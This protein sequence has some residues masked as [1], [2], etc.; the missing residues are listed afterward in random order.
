VTNSLRLETDTQRVTYRLAVIAAHRGA[1]KNAREA[2][3]LALQVD[4]G[5]VDGLFL[6]GRIHAQG[7]EYGKAEA[8][9]QRAVARDPSRRDIEA[10]LDY[11][12][13][14]PRLAKWHFRG[15]VAILAGTVVFSIGLAAWLS[16]QAPA[17]TIR[18]QR[19]TIPN[20]TPGTGS[21]ARFVELP[22]LP[23][24]LQKDTSGHYVA[25]IPAG[26]LFS[27]NLTLSPEGEATIRDMVALIAGLPVGLVFELTGHSDSIPLRTDTQWDNAE[28]AA[29]RALIIARRLRVATGLPI[30]RFV[31]KSVGSEHPLASNGSEV[32]RLKNRTVVVR[33]VD[34]DGVGAV[35]PQSP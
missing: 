35:R 11:L 27:K 20:K 34:P 13:K 8:L 7:G 14:S 29:R 9:W 26:G 18:A 31:V 10:S 17:A 3:D 4:P 15:K 33:V 16:L 12:K 22:P 2:L 5:W 6:L 21:T 28:L 23:P 24:T 19:E 1:T 30:D 25:L 32:G